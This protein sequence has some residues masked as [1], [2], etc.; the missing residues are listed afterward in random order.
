MAVVF[1]GMA[2]SAVLRVAWAWFG[3]CV[4]LTMRDTPCPTPVDPVLSAFLVAELALA[5]VFLGCARKPEW[6]M[7]V[8]WVALIVLAARA[9]ADFY[10]AL[11]FP[12]SAAMAHLF[13]LVLVLALLSGWL[14]AIPD[15]LRAA[16]E[17]R[18]S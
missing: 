1:Y 5:L 11:T 10:G 18:G 3:G 15:T 13:D 9:L 12:A 4:A 7:P 2:V 8:V 17:A 6:H 16:R 14:R